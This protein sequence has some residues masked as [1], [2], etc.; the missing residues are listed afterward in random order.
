[1]VE[2]Y[3]RNK[4]KPA[5]QDISELMF[6]IADEKITVTYHTEDGK[7]SASTREFIKPANADEKG[8]TLI[9]SPDMH[10]SFQVTN[11]KSA[12]TINWSLVS[13]VRKK[14]FLKL[15]PK[16]TTYVRDKF[17]PALSY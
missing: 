4:A 3:H 1:M 6:L 15:S 9:M 10:T 14:K 8:A 11:F 12:V 17:S 16:L 2:K 7:I 13:P 5:S